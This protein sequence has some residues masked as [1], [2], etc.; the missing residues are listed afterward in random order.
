MKV[1]VVIFAGFHLLD[2][3]GP[4]ATLD[5]ARR[6]APVGYDIVAMAAD[7]GAIA[8]SSGIA[9]Q[10]APLGD[11]PFDTVMVAGGEFQRGVDDMA[12]IV[13]WLRREAPRARRIASVSTGAFLLAEAGLLE[14]RH[15][16]THW[17]ATHAFNRRYP[18]IA[19]DADRIFIRDGAIWTSGGA[20]AGID[21]SLAL[22]EDD[23]GHET[24][25]RTAQLLVVHQ[26]RAG[27]QSQHSALVDLGGISGR[28]AGL[29]D[30]IGAN[31]AEPLSVEQLAAEARMS[32]RH[33]ARTFAQEVGVTPA[34]AV[35]K[36]RIDQAR[37]R[38]ENSRDQIEEVARSCGFGDPERMR[39]A[40]VRAFG[41][42]PIVFRPAGRSA[43]PP[44]KTKE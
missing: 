30:W 1:V 21:L 40:F 20:T 4:I 29:I 31:L 10:A 28:F 2:A 6:F 26:R 27:G 17:G 33:F 23:F 44:G 11:G 24:A 32:P 12:A 37:A 7:G 8:S 25:R 35:E 14:R 13:T 34:K 39:R 16:T 5:L 18:D 15:A 3:T 38:I 42:P 41:L 19:L 22:I 43:A 9:L 36:V